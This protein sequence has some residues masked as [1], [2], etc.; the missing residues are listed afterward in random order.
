MR[1]WKFR[2]G[3]HVRGQNSRIPLVRSCPFS[4]S[5]KSVGSVQTYCW[6][7]IL[8]ASEVGQICIRK[9]RKNTK[10]TLD[11]GRSLVYGQIAPKVRL[12]GSKFRRE[13]KEGFVHLHIKEK[14][15]KSMSRKLV[16]FAHEYCAYTKNTFLDWAK[17][18]KSQRLYNGV[19]LKIS[20][21]KGHK[22]CR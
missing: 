3:R 1:V 21:T 13:V 6:E 18:A 15:E 19:M 7:K 9:C 20:P 11:W 22:E 8:G 2:G 10:N 4:V 5:W 16:E 14:Y 12:T 17:I